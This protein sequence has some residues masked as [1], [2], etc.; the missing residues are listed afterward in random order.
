MFAVIKTGGKQ[1]KLAPED[2]VKI[3]KIPGNPGDSVQF[4]KVLMIGDGAS[5]TFGTPFLEG[6]SVSA[7]ILSQERSPKITVFKKKQRS[8]YRRT[9]GHR[10]DLT[11]VRI[12]G[13][14]ADGQQKKTT[15][16]KTPAAKPAP[17]KAAASVA[18]S[19][20][21]ATAKTPAPKKA[22]SATTKKDDLKKL[23]GVG[24]VLEKKLHA[25]GITSFAQ[26]SGWT[27]S[28]IARFDEELDFK[29]RIEREG[30]VKQAKELAQD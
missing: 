24:P 11:R 6:A 26:I 21:K 25:A 9:Q 2:S 20:D 4:D 14:A 27:K 5:V 17:A 8:T 23:S 15:A 3:E 19:A 16:K 10:Q 30:W 13:I 12:L 1:Y 22:S 7:E 18:K 28:D 29:G